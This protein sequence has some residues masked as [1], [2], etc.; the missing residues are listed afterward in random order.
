MTPLGH[1]SVSYLAGKSCSCLLPAFVIVG[2]F[3]PDFDFIL[4]PFNFF[5]ELHRKVSHNIF[6]ILLF[7]GF[8]AYFQKCGKNK[9]SV[10][11]SL[12]LGGFLH[13]FID[14][15]MDTNPSNG[16]GVAAFWPV[17]EG[18]VSPFNI[19]TK[20]SETINWNQ[21]FKMIQYGSRYLIYEIPLLFLAILI[22][23]IKRDYA[24]LAKKT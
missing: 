2:G 14:S 5:N 9:W 6:F 1:A 23:I 21:P 15:I 7:S 11:F 12:I 10:F 17:W 8:I 19:A 13:L 3:L 18:Y 16:I 20:T 24:I 22:I 4:L